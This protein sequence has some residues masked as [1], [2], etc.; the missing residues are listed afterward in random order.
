MPEISNTKLLETRV[1]KCFT[2]SGLEGERVG[3]SLAENGVAVIKGFIDEKTLIS[4]KSDAVNCTK[5]G[6]DAG[7]AYVCGVL[8]DDAVDGVILAIPPFEMAQVAA[9]AFAA[10]KHVLCEKP[11]GIGVAQA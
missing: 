7:M 2:L 11:L 9:A 5:D 3:R 4:L 10:R 1:E 6:F 8:K